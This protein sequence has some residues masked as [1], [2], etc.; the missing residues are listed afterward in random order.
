L[1]VPLRLDVLDLI[2]PATEM[3]MA[4]AD[5]VGMPSMASTVVM[6][7]RV[8]IEERHVD[9][10]SDAELATVCAW[11]GSQLDW[12]VLQPWVDELASDVSALHHYA[13]LVAPWEAERKMLHTPC[14]VCD[15]KALVFYGGE[16]RITCVRSV[17]G[18]GHDMDDHDYKRLVTEALTT[19]RAST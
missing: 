7:C 18:C 19:G 11:L 6:W 13:R 2:G 10:P 4:G 14:P 15:V 5:Q 9:P 17:G 8:V 1:P 16:N 3:P 12:L